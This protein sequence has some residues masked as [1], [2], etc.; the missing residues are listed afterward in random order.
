MPWFGG[1]ALELV[2]LGKFGKVEG[3]GGFIFRQKM[4]V[5]RGGAVRC[6]AVRCAR[7]GRRG[8]R[9]WDENG[10][11]RRGLPGVGDEQV[12]VSPSTA[13]CSVDS[14]DRRDLSIVNDPMKSRVVVQT[15]GAGADCRFL[16]GDGEDSQRQG[17]LDDGNTFSSRQRR[18]GFSVGISSTLHCGLCKWFF[19]CPRRLNRST[20]T[21]VGCFGEKGAAMTSRRDPLSGKT[22]DLQ[23]GRRRS[24]A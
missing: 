16:D 9:G 20:M 1:S 17:G 21:E 12:N 23:S 4:E 13:V 11:R 15:A 7:G 6:G 14:V 8:R 19:Y 5:G 22:V 3:N 10:R 2:V 18:D 24:N